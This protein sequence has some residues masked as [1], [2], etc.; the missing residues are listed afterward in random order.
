MTDIH[1]TLA[2]YGVLADGTKVRV[3]HAPAAFLVPRHLLKREM[4]AWAREEGVYAKAC[5]LLEDGLYSIL[6]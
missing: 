4:I 1:D 5:G 2:R 6:G 3:S